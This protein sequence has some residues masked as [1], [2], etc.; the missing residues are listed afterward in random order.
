MSDRPSRRRL[1]ALLAGVALTV[2]GAVLA[3]F[4]VFGGD[5]DAPA[6]GPAPS[7]SASCAVFDWDCQEPTA[8]PEPSDP[9]TT[10]VPTGSPVIPTSPI[11]RVEPTSPGDGTGGSTGGIGAG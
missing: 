6:P 10:A 11:P 2:V 5:P 3:A 9:P 8:A 4:A 1:G 7:P